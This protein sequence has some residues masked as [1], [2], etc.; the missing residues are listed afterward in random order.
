MGAQALSEVYR[1]QD[2]AAAEYAAGLLQEWSTRRTGSGGNSAAIDTPDEDDA[3]EGD[4]GET[5]E[6]KCERFWD[7]LNLTKSKGKVNLTVKAL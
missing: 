7:S 6:F 3:R 5:W 1:A 4:K 2:E